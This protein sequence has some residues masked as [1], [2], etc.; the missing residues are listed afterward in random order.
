M[1]LQKDKNILLKSNTKFL[2]SNKKY[3]LRH[4]KRL[5]VP[6]EGVGPCF[7]ERQKVTQW[8]YGN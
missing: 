7:Q 5:F 6:N 4:V 3:L 2:Y 1:L 8:N